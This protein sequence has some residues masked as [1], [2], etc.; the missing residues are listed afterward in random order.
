MRRYSAALTKIDI[1]TLFDASIKSEVGGV[2]QLLIRPNSASL[3]IVSQA[4]AQIWSIDS[5]SAPAFTISTPPGIDSRWINHPRNP[6]QLLVFNYNGVTLHSWENLRTLASFRYG[7]ADSTTAEYFND[8]RRGSTL[9]Y[10]SGTTFSAS[11]MT[12]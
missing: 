12:E 3:L 2:Q 10:M 1:Q 7:T 6:E 8:D 4:S 11:D 5:D 9:S